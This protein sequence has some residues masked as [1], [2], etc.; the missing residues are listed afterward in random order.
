MALRSA[1]RR[2]IAEDKQRWS[3]IGWATKNV[4][5]RAPPCLRRRV[6]PLV[7]AEYA[8]VSTHQLA[9]G[10]RG[11][12]WPVLLLCPIKGDINRLMMMIKQN[13]SKNVDAEL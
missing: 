2:A 3:V 12:L 6:K 11:G 10:P 9:L 1:L 8:A 4:L 7:T 13:K 5:S